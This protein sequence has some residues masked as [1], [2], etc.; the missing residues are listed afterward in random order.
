[1]IKWKL[2]LLGALLGLVASQIVWRC[3]HAATCHHYSRWYYSFR[4]SCQSTT[5]GY[6]TV[7]PPERPSLSMEDA[8]DNEPVWYV[9]IVVPP[10]GTVDV[11]DETRARDELRK[12]LPLR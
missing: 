7:A 2:V 10:P 1:M 3:A 5:V 6:K 11:D 12:L 8:D 9:E 4:Q